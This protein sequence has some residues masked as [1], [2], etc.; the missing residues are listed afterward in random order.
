[1][2][3][4]EPQNVSAT[5]PTSSLSSV[6]A[7]PA[8][9]IPLCEAHKAMDR[10][11]AGLD[12]SSEVLQACRLLRAF[13]TYSTGSSLAAIAQAISEASSTHLL[14]ALAQHIKTSIII[15]LKAAG[16][17]TPASSL[18]SPCPLGPD[19]VDYYMNIL[20]AQPCDQGTL[21]RLCLLRDGG[22]CVFTGI[23]DA[24]LHENGLAYTQVAHIVPYALGYFDERNSVQLEARATVWD[25]IVRM[26]PDVTSR[27]NF[28]GNQINNL[29]N[30]ITLCTDLHV[31]FGAFRCCLTPIDDADNAH[32]YKLETFP[33]FPRIYLDRI[34][35]DRIIR[36]S[37]HDQRLELPSRHLLTLHSVIARVLNATGM[38]QLIDKVFEERSNL[39]CLAEDGSTDIARLL[40]LAS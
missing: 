1:M 7:N 21:R 39:R 23:E 5:S 31:A 3:S 24:N 6:S 40:L 28:N 15:P 32:T 33:H 14:L 27:L 22:R 38:G 2:T 11:L 16:G 8:T 20:E 10:A 29:C 37:T 35:G 25:A 18:P 36:L 19:D 9:Y 4:P 12:C 34:P 13:L 26:F 30:V 17:K